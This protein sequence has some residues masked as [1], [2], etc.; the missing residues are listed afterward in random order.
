[1]DCNIAVNMGRPLGIQDAGISTPLPLQ[2]SDDQLHDSV[3]SHSPA[4]VTF[5]KVTNTSTFIHIIKLR[6]IM[7]KSIGPSI[8][9]GYL[10]CTRRAGRLAILILFGAEHVAG[11]S[12][13]IS[14]HSF[15]FPIP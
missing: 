10:V 3:E 12:S 4:S 8:L 1:M 7:R 13:E 15:D 2:L 11:H 9:P 14:P 6:R 5:P